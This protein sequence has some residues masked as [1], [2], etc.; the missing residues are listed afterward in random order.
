MT[1]TDK[2]RTIAEQAI[3]GDL[4][5]YAYGNLNKYYPIVGTYTEFRGEY[6]T[7]CTYDIGSDLSYANAN[8]KHIKP[9]LRPLSWITREITH[10][11]YNN[12]ESFVPTDELKRLNLIEDVPYMNNT[13][14]YIADLSAFGVTHLSIFEIIDLLNQW[15]INW[16]NLPET[17]FV[18]TEEVG[19]IYAVK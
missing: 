3:Y 5:G 16:R 4:K 17:D 13:E 2:Q 9:I 11:N 12:G 18:S 19:D 10:A 6:L 14:L 15:H 7:Y 8:I 1:P